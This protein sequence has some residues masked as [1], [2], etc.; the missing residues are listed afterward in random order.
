M[1][2]AC[3]LLLVACT[4]DGTD[5]P[6]SESTPASAYAG[7]ALE[8]CEAQAGNLDEGLTSIDT[9][10]DGLESESFDDRAVA[11]RALM[12]E[13]SSQSVGLL[14]RFNSLDAPA[15]DEEFLEVM[16]QGERDYQDALTEG[17]SIAG[18]ATSHAELDAALET[19][20][21]SYAD[22]LDARAA[23]AAASGDLKTA[24]RAEPACES[25]F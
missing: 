1:V 25:L 11:V 10:A 22:D 5:D 2:A 6:A 24:L 21:A 4:G 17:R 12:A 14:D 23:F 16:I 9:Y 19:V 7:Y 15:G 20:L 3:M 8:L 18:E 13:L